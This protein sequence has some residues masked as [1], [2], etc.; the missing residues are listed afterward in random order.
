[1]DTSQNIESYYN[2]DI[3]ADDRGR[4]YYFNNAKFILIFFVVL[5][6]AISPFKNTN[7]IAYLVWNFLNI[8]H[9]PCFIMISGFFSKSYIKGK[10]FNIQKVF[11]YF[12]LY[13]ASQVT[14]TLFEFFVMGE[15]LSPSFLSPRGSLWFLQCL[16]GWYILL[17]FIARFKKSY[18]IPAT[19]IIGL[20][21]GF[22]K[23]A[24]T[25]F[26]FSRLFVHLP[27]FMIGYYLDRETIFT[28]TS[29][30]KNKIL[31][32]GIIALVSFAIYRLFLKLPAGIIIASKPYS[33]IGDYG[34]QL[35]IVNRFIFY[36]VALLLIF[37]FM[38]LVPKKKTLFTQFGSRTLAVYILHR[39]LYLPYLKYNWSVYFEGV[40]GIMGLVGVVILVVL[41]FSS[42][43][44]FK[45]FQGIMNIKIDHL[46][47]NDNT[48]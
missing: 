26:S 46:L 21:I 2:A 9:M 14:L 16:F 42:S 13:F 45:P 32:I 17:P 1:M 18:V 6:H 48:K 4:I 23:S 44:F 19:F 7:K 36:I 10:T 28:I 15:S 5:A 41:I 22:D 31:S 25:V 3:H 40:F 35:Q 47:E 37:A 30:F 27:F 34:F 11:T 43:L 8:L 24:N 12:L 38:C 39:F 29:K 33:K 20:L